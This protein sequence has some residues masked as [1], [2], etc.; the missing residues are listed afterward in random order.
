MG[1]SYSVPKWLSV[2]P[3]MHDIG[4]GFENHHLETL[5]LTPPL[6]IVKIEIVKCY[7]NPSFNQK[8][9]E[10]FLIKQGELNFQWKLSLFWKTISDPPCGNPE[11]FKNTLG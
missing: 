11:K 3:Y 6:Y 1:E 5:V 4:H 7:K 9:L 2:D 8:Q 10:I